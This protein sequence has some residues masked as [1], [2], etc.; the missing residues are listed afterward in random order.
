VCMRHSGWCVC[1]MGRLT[2]SAARVCARQ[3]G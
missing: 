1:R 3:P 2:A